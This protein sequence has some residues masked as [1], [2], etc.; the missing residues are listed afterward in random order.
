MNFFI[1]INEFEEKYIQ[2]KTTDFLNY[3][4]VCENYNLSHLKFL[5]KQEK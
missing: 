3:F 2:T 5:K 4:R 1:D